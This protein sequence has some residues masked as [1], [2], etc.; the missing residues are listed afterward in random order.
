MFKKKIC[1]SCNEKVKDKFNFCP[2]CG[3][4]FNGTRRSEDFGMLG[5]NDSMP[6]IA[7]D[8]KL[9]FG[10]GKMVNSLVKQLE[11]QMNNSNLG[12]NIEGAPKGFK[13]KVSTGMPQMK[14]VVKEAS[15]EVSISDNI[16]P[17]ESERR[18]KLPRVDAESRVRRLGDR[19]IYEIETQGVKSK[20]DV[21]LTKLATG[22]EVKAYSKDKCY[23]R[24]IPLTVEIVGYFVKQ[25]KVYVE[26][27]A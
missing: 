8:L 20:K 26:L 15:P 22:I 5:K 9:P 12:E 7:G 10:L 19:I 24:F 17:K 6:N 27:K 18:M 2:S 11:Q 21:V 3:N 23:V 14:Q 16:N 4:S 25:N 13:I 1:S